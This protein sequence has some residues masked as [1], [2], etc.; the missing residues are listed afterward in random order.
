VT[1]GPY[2]DAVRALADTPFSSIEYRPE[3]ESTNA[4]AAAILGGARRGGHTIVA[5]YQRR[6]TGRKNRS[7]IA[8]PDSALLFTTILPG[9]IDA[10]HLWLVPFWTGLAVHH[11][12][13]AF[14]IDALLQWPNDVLL[15]GGKLAGILCLS[16]VTGDRARV[17][18][19]IGL[20]AHRTREGFAGAAYCDD[21]APVAKAALLGGILGRFNETLPLLHDLGGA[22]AR[23][24]SAAAIPGARYRIA[25]DNSPTPFDAT[26]LALEMGGALRVQRDDGAIVLVDMADARILRE[27][28]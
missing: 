7:W 14:G 27:K 19:G 5:G 8:P 20:N 4:D 13:R 26:A 17:A 21:V 18:C 25:L 15:N 9:E 11:V 22:V 10:R 24:E 3:T 16:Q 12:V 28:P 1:A 6:G 2:A 23:W